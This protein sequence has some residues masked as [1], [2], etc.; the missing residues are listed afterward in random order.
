LTGY[1]T[2]NATASNSYGGAVGINIL[3]A[4]FRRQ[5]VTE[6][7]ALD[8]YGNPA[9]SAAAGP[10]Y[11]IGTRYQQSI[12]NRTLWRVD[13]MNGFFDNAPDIYGTRVEF[14]WKF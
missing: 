13:L 1:P 6:F 2:L 14:R 12:N 5:W 8:T 4:D 9:L 7:A 10:E 11:A 3:S